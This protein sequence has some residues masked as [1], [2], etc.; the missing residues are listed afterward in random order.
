[1]VHQYG[2]WVLDCDVEVRGKLTTEDEREHRVRNGEI[3]E[4]PSTH[5]LRTSVLAD[6]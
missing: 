2:D 4:K 3:E 1:M 6:I 5:L